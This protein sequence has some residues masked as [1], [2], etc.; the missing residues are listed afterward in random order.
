MKFELCRQIFEK[1]PNKKFRE[2]RYSGSI[3]DE[4]SIRFS[5]FCER[6]WQDEYLYK[7][8]I[9][10]RCGAE[11]MVL[12]D[13]SKISACGKDK[14]RLCNRT[15]NKFISEQFVCSIFHVNGIKTA[16]SQAT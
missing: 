13:K 16:K 7:I 3:H 9:L 1:Y 5:Q 15:R 12:V 14:E 10:N 6:P 8:D 2:K 11:D 4:A